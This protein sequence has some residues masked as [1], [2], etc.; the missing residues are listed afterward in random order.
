MVPFF[1]CD[2][3][4]EIARKVTPTSVCIRIFFKGPLSYSVSHSLQTL[5][6]TEYYDQRPDMYIMIA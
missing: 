2:V 4:F 3:E 5:I 6:S 1:L